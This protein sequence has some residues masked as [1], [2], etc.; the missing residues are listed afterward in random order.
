MYNLFV[1]F[2]KTLKYKM[3]YIKKYLIK[4]ICQIVKMI[5]K[6]PSLKKLGYC[7]H[8]ELESTI[9]KGKDDNN[10]IKSNGKWNNIR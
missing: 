10:W 2:N 4:Y 1:I 3:N 9:I 5:V 7:T 6:E 8:A